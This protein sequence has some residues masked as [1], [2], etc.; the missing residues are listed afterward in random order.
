MFHLATTAFSMLAIGD[1][2]ATTYKEGSCC[3]KYRKNKDKTSVDYQRDYHAQINIATLMSQSAAEKKPEMVMGHGDN[4]YWNGVGPLDAEGR[5]HHTF[6]E[7]YNQPSLK[8]VP[9]VN[10]AGNHDIGGSMYIC[11]EQDNRFRPCK[12]SAELIKYL[13]LK[14]NL[15]RDYKSPDNNRWIMSD[16]YYKKTV[17]KGGVSVDIFN[18][19]TNY[20]DSHAAHQV[21]CQ[22]Y[23]YS[24]G[25]KGVECNNVQKG[26][27]F[28]A[29][30][31]IAMYSACMAHIKTWWDDS[32]DN[33]QKDLKTSTATFK[34][35]NTHYSPHFH[36]GE[37]KMKLWYKILA[38]NAVH[39]WFNGHTHGFNHDISK[40]ET[41]FFEN[42][43]GGGIQSETSGHRPEMAAKFVDTEWIGAGD[44]YGFFELS[45]SEDWL[46]VQFVTFDQGWKFS[47]TPNAVVPGG[48]DRRHCW[49]I[50]RIGGPGKECAA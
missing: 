34:I 30:G 45:F 26:D 33:I 40:W 50:P 29:G 43:G 6:D 27:K 15:Q 32:V 41:H 2:G 12:S 19:D 11:G 48:L 24:D 22:C 49:H 46:K 9:W 21:C 44:P 23:G 17:S 31:D 42:G 47:L 3:N 5:M 38:D 16:H 4:V 28:C 35:V 8:G 18:I 7:V 25:G 14:F 37:N 10:V 1:W 20:A 39:A 13:D 36:M